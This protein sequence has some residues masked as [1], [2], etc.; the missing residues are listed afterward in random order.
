MMTA[1]D[2]E[3]RKRSITEKRH[4]GPRNGAS[5]SDRKLRLNGFLEFLG[6]AEGDL[7]AGL[8]LDRLAGGG[9]APDAGGAFAGL[10]DAEP[11]DPDPLALLQVLCDPVHH[12]GQDRLGRLLRQLMWLGQ[13]RR[14]MFQG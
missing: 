12:V 9:G 1:S 11:H 8:D 13:R 14:Q 5:M 10:E 2:F 4:P 7:L 6:G 3:R